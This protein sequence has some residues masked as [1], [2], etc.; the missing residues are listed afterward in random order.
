MFAIGDKK[1]MP[2]PDYSSIVINAKNGNVRANRS[3][4]LGRVLRDFDY[5]KPSAIEDAVQNQL[6]DAQMADWAAEKERAGKAPDDGTISMPARRKRAGLCISVFSTSS[7]RRAGQPAN[8]WVFYSGI[9]VAIFQLG[10]ASIPCALYDQWSILLITACGT[11]LASLSG[12]LPQWKAEKWQ[13]RRGSK[14]VI[15]T[16]GNG[17]QHAIVVIGA[18]DALNLEDLAVSD[19][20]KSSLLL[21]IFAAFLATLW[22]VFLVSVAGVKENTWFLLAVGGLGMMHNVLV[23]ETPRKPK[24]FGLHLELLEVIGHRE[25]MQALMNLEDKHP[26]VGTSLVPTFFPGK[27]RDNEERFWKQKALEL[28]EAQTKEASEKSQTRRAPSSSS[29]QVMSISAGSCIK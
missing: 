28:A 18:G 7:A 25:T 6:N 3:W 21:K 9:L 19:G 15:L 4:V 27:L 14:T 1:L 12:S 5:W 13:C 20:E 22:L 26:G 11:L 10:I 24:A 23:A 29:P 2:G 17:A 8:D 16:Q